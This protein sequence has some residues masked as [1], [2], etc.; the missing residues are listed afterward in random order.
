MEAKP[1]VIS[2]D[3]YGAAEVVLRAIAHQARNDVPCKVENTEKLKRRDFQWTK[4]GGVFV[5]TGFFETEKGVALPVSLLLGKSEGLS[6]KDVSTLTRRQM[7]STRHF[8][9]GSAGYVM[10]IDP[11]ILDPSNQRNIRLVVNEV[12]AFRIK[13]SDQDLLELRKAVEKAHRKRSLLVAGLG[14]WI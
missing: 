1:L 7:F 2:A 9:C 11:Q 6:L 4:I 13:H 12:C 14:E 5:A 8:V 3:L 10:P